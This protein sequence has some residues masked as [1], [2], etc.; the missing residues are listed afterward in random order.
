VE[1]FAHEER[2][3]TDVLADLEAEVGPRR[4]R[5]L[6]L[7]VPADRKAAIVEALAA[8]PPSHVGDWAVREVRT[9]DGV[10]LVTEG[11]RWVLVR[12]SGTEP[13][14]RV[15]LEAENDEGLAALAQFAEEHL[16]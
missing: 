11:D 10:K 4:S 5:R 14:L 13:L 2:P 6:D 7:E 9:I 15:Y 3:L 16:S 12:P 1:L 8:E